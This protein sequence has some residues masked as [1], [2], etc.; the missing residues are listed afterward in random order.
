VRNSWSTVLALKFG[1]YYYLDGK[2]TSLVSVSGDIGI[3]A[4]DETRGDRWYLTS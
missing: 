4:Y 3:L 1:Y 2:K